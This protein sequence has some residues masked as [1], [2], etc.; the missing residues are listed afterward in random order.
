MSNHIETMG[1]VTDTIRKLNMVRP[2]QKTTLEN[3]ET[4]ELYHTQK[5]AGQ[6]D[7]NDCAITVRTNNPVMPTAMSNHIETMGRVTDT[8]RKLNMVR[9]IQKTTL[10]K[11]LPTIMRFQQSWATLPKR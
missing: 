3:G 8:I 11:Y 1:R 7:T 2:I 9:P 6:H 4:V 10:E 5:Q